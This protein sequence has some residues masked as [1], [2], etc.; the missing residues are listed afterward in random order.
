MLPLELVDTILD[1]VESSVTLAACTLVCRD[2]L[3]S[4]RFHLLSHIQLES[5]KIDSFLEHLDSDGTRFTA[6]LA[7]VVSLRIDG[8]DLS[9]APTVLPYKF[10]N[11]QFLSFKAFQA[12]SFNVIVTWLLANPSLRSLTLS[13]D[14]DD[15]EGESAA[16]VYEGPTLPNLTHLD[17]DCP[18][19]ALL[20]WLLSQ[21]IGPTPSSLVLRDAIWDE[22]VS[23]IG[24]YFAV[25]GNRLESL[26]LSFPRKASRTLDLTQLSNLRSLTFECYSPAMPR[27]VLHASQSPG[28]IKL[29]N[30]TMTFLGML[31]V[32]PTEED[33]LAWRQLN[34]HLCSAQSEF[35][36]LRTIRFRG[37]SPNVD[38][39]QLL[40]LP[41]GV[42]SIETENTCMP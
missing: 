39:K 40:P 13:G 16:A 5:A 29:E 19:Q 42:A 17:L 23:I 30:L 27:L 20:C 8:F 7:N 21:P 34:E 9:S 24:R 36:Q 25:V 28:L 6:T 15:S 22:E 11:L 33:R 41:I 35:R 1:F 12:D 4:A 31:A 37:M 26:V 2:W 38:G 18:L 10:P 32:F 14:W 3:A